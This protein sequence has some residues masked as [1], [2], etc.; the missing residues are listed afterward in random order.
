[1]DMSGQFHAAAALPREMAPCAQQTE[2][3]ID[4]ID[5]MDA[6]KNV[7]I[8]SPPW[9]LNYDLLVLQPVA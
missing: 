3:W 6:S 2:G 7:K 9:D 5:K 8:S 4:P 1:M